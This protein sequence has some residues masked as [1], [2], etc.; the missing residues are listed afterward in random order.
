M[1]GRSWTYE[2]V[3]DA[4]VDV[5]LVV[6]EDVRNVSLRCSEHGISVLA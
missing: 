6:V 1:L 5:L 2:D 3:I 4:E